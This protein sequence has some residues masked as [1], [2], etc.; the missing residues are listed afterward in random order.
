MT[1]QI[2]SALIGVGIAAAILFLVRRDHLHGPYAFWWLFVAVATTL[3]GLFPSIVDM[4]GRLTG[5]AYPPVL[6]LILALAMILL[7]MLRVDIDRSRHE[8]DTRR[9]TQK[10]ALLEQELSQLRSQREREN[11]TPQS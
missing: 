10:I 9:L 3:L 4:L 2:T 11:H 7:R 5:I 8:R 1:A 6:A